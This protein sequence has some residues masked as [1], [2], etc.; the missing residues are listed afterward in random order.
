MAHFDAA[1]LLDARVRQAAFAF[2]D[3]QRDLHGD[4]LPWSV[5]QTGFDL[6]GRRVPLSSMQGIFKP[7]VLAR[8]PLSIRTA[9]PKPG[10]EPPYDDQIGADGLIRYRYQGSDPNSRDNVW[11]R[12]AFERGLPLV[13][14]HGVEPGWYVAAYPVRI[15]YDDPRALAVTVAV[16]EME[17]TDLGRALSLGDAVAEPVRRYTTRM[18]VS[19]LHQ[20]AFRHRVLAAYGQRCAVCRLRHRRLLDAAHII[21]DREH[22]GD[23]VVSNGLS[24][25]KLHHAAYDADVMGIRPDLIVEIRQDVLRE[26]DGPML[27]HGLQ[28]VDGWKLVAPASRAKRPDPARLDV[29]YKRFRS[30]G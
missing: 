7:E 16:D 17:A 12:H 19:R 23:P 6:D 1:D 24:L 13:Y 30:A 10:T 25:C 27:R 28:E 2:L 3:V 22:G 18:A 20:S 5:L 21:G 4:V 15:V 26:V 9:P 11:L 14:L 8:A 29:R